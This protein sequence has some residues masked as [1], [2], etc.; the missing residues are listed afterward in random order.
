M[1]VTIT[2]RGS[3]TKTGSAT[4]SLVIDP[5]DLSGVGAQPTDILLGVVGSL[6]RSAGFPFLTGLTKID[7]QSGGLGGLVS[8]SDRNL[9]SG[10]ISTGFTLDWTGWGADDVV[11]TFYVL[12]WEDDGTPGTWGFS[13]TF[14]EYALDANNTSNGSTHSCS[15][16]GQHGDGLTSW[17]AHVYI[18]AALVST[19]TPTFA[20]ELQE[21]DADPWTGDGEASII[22]TDSAASG[23]KTLYSAVGFGQYPFDG[24]T[25]DEPRLVRSVASVGGA[26]NDILISRTVHVV[27]TEPLVPNVSPDRTIYTRRHA[28]AKELPHRLDTG[29]LRGL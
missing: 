13:N 18:A 23:G 2:P 29:L 9:S 25:N 7:G 14:G 15:S 17:W 4:E 1:A 28:S 16:N 8:V 12:G 3:F 24:V 10:D 11:A 26:T 22:D 21:A 5:S 19:G 20:V 6:T 27:T